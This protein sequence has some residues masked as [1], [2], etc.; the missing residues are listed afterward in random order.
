MLYYIILYVMTWLFPWEK[1]LQM[2]HSETY[3]LMDK[4]GIRC[5]VSHAT[6]VNADSTW[7]Q[8]FPQMGP[9]QTRGIARYHIHR[10]IPREWACVA[11][12][13]RRHAPTGYAHR[14][15]SSTPQAHP[16]GYW[17]IL[18][19]D[20][21]DWE[22]RNGSWKWEPMVLEKSQWLMVIGN[23]KWHRMILR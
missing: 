2:L 14:E 5:N 1:R 7:S 17:M 20:I 4:R 19:N 9:A 16:N 10:G 21:G 12:W 8:I 23:D 15:M 6:C 13:R 3:W 18:R 11:F 22:M